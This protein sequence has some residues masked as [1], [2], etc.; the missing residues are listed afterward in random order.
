MMTYTTSGEIANRAGGGRE[1]GGVKEREGDGGWERG[2][3]KEKGEGGRGGGEGRKGER[4]Y[5]FPYT[6]LHTAKAKVSSRPSSL[7]VLT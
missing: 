3:G 5:S 2:R 1:E 7:L 4:A 6:Y